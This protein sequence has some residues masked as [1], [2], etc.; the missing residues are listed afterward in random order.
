MA[1]ESGLDTTRG[2][3]DMDNIWAYAAD[4]GYGEDR[5]L[6]GF[7][8]EATDGVVGQV[9]RQ[10][11]HDGMR[12]LVVDTGMWVFGTSLLIPA[13]LITGIDSDTRRVV[14]GR[15]REEIK[16]APRFA[17]DSETTDVAYL[18]AVGNYYQ[19]LGPVPVS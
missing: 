11:D 5:S 12:H 19:A 18:S 10:T 17:R 13:G 15:A 9:E 3:T 8:V 7:E 2:E 1:V 6:V 4:C 16:A 14:V